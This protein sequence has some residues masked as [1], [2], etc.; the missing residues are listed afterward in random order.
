MN[1]AKIMIPKVSTVFLHETDTVRQGLERFL[2]HGYTAVPVLND[3]EQYVGSVTEGDLLRHILSVGTTD[4]KAQEEYRIGAI[5][6][7]DFCPPLSISA[8]DG[9][10]VS[11]TL[12]QNFV[13]IIDD[14]GVLCGILTRRGLILSLAQQAGL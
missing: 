5:L 9:E 8:G 10:M 3:R 11:A 12:N 7:K 4:L 2:I 1:I 14:R 6:R 13:P